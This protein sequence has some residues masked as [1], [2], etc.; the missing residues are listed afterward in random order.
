VPSA[1]IS[2]S[3]GTTPLRPAARMVAG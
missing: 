2:A 3:R 1:P